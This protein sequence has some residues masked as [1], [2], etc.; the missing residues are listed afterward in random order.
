MNNPW[1]N[2]ADNSF[3]N[4]QLKKKI[5]SNHPEILNQFKF[6][7]SGSKFYTASVCK[8][9]SF[10]PNTLISSEYDLKHNLIERFSSFSSCSSIENISTNKFNDNLLYFTLYPEIIIFDTNSNE[11]INK[12]NC[13]ISRWNCD[14]DCL[15]EASKHHANIIFF[16]VKEGVFRRIKSY[17]LSTSKIESIFSFYTKSEDSIFLNHP[18]NKNI[19]AVVDNSKILFFDT[20]G[21][22][23]KANFSPYATIDTAIEGSNTSDQ[24]RV[25]SIKFN[26]NGSKLVVNMSN[27]PSFIL[28][29]V[30]FKK[31]IISIREEILNA[32]FMRDDNYIVASRLNND[33]IFYS[34]SKKKVIKTINQDVSVFNFALSPTERLL[35]V[36]TLEMVDEE[37]YTVVKTYK[38]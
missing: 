14:D 7:S 34:R 8:L 20:K 21:F 26:S 16:T 35:A 15:I 38:F 4:I 37:D 17:D 23:C 22:I 19:F 9:K 25:M 1:S 10:D 31:E 11:I 28:D 5:I 2:I 30:V 18:T 6:N 36:N 24:K 32:D 29:T 13:N 3:E 12:V 27:S 33:I